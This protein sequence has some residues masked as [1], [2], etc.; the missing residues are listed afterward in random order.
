MKVHFGCAESESGIWTIYFDD[1]IFNVPSCWEELK[2]MSL[3][4]E[5]VLLLGVF[6]WSNY[7]HSVIN[8][9]IDRK[10]IFMK[11]NIGLAAF[12]PSSFSQIELICPDILNYNYQ[13]NTEPWMIV[14]EQGSLKKARSGPIDCNLI[15]NWILNIDEKRVEE[16]GSGLETEN[17]SA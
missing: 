14:I 15:L 17:G 16:K 2:Q 10:N 11:Y 6:D 5:K 1:P 7:S 9:I 13:L 3:E 4:C 8:D 12:C